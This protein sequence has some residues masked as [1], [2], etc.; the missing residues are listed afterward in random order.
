VDLSRVTVVLT[1]FGRHEFTPRWLAHA[2]RELRGARVLLADGSPDDLP[3][4]VLEAM[5]L[6][7]GDLAL[8]Y[9]RYPADKDLLD[10]Q[11]KLGDA[12]SKVQTPYVMLADNDDFHCGDGVRRAVAALDA[13]ASLVSA[14][15]RVTGLR[16]A[17]RVDGLPF[18]IHARRASCFDYEFRQALDSPR[19]WE[20]VQLNS[21]RYA[22]SWYALTRTQ[23]A[24]DWSSRVASEP[25]GDMGLVEWLQ[26]CLGCAAGPRLTAEWPFLFRQH[27]VTAKASDVLRRQADQIDR[28]CLPG[29]SAD[30]S[31][32]VSAVAE[33]I[34]SS[35]GIPEA[36]A[37]A[38][39]RRALH[40]YLQTRILR[41]TVSREARSYAGIRW[42]L[43]VAAGR[44]VQQWVGGG[45]HGVLS[46]AGVH[47]GPTAGV[48][49]VLPT[50]RG[51]NR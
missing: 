27:N 38:H 10:Y 48:G 33:A 16:V 40:D 18:P 13:D 44:V 4:E 11:R 46:R 50:L 23:V 32:V 34:R 30:C 25:I 36:Q 21:R 8:T 19:A 7:E 17:G 37:A 22:A 9:I 14:R 1:L 5:R 15:G 26:S 49:C 41:Q 6:A 47:L 29:W 20:R 35:D 51:R 43:G 2:R 42:M 39:A 3:S 24:R 45:L 31:R 12:I 28:L